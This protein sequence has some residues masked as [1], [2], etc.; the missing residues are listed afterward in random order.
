MARG[1]FNMEKIRITEG[2]RQ[3]IQISEHF[4]LLD[5]E[6]VSFHI[7]IIKSKQFKKPFFPRKHFD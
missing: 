7:I 6:L 1:P 5:F 4:E 2:T 3:K